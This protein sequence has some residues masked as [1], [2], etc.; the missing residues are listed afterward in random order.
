MTHKQHLPRES[1]REKRYDCFEVY[2]NPVYWVVLLSLHKMIE[3]MASAVEG[4]TESLQP[5]QGMIHK[6]KVLQRKFHHA[7]RHLKPR[8][9]REEEGRNDFSNRKVQA[10]CMCSGYSHFFLKC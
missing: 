4:C 10:V 7:T 9:K 3:M 1:E 8:L 2:I 6:Q 5:C